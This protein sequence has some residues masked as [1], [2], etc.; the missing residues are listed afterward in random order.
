MGYQIVTVQ[1]LDG[2]LVND[3]TIVGGVITSVGGRSE[4]PFRECDIGS[5]VVKSR[6]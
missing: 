4:I 6:S 5:I 3:V 2:S 1:L